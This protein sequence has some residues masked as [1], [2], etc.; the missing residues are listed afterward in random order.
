[1]L[2]LYMSLLRTVKSVIML[3]NKPGVETRTS[4]FVSHVIKDKLKK[5]YVRIIP[6]FRMEL[7]TIPQILFYCC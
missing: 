3:I 2:A 4:A 1:M 6:F 5:R 7:D